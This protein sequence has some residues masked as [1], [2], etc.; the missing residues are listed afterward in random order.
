M[1][2]AGSQPSLIARVPWRTLWRSWWLSLAVYVG[3]ILFMTWPLALHATTHLPQGPTLSTSVPLFNLWTFE[4][5]ADRALHG[6]RDYWHAPIFHPAREA[7]AFSEPQPT[8]LLLAP[9]IWLTGSGE[10]AY[11]VYF[12]LALLLNAVV[13]EAL[14]RDRGVG[15]GL[16][17]AGGVA[18]LLLPVAHW[19]RDVLQLVP[20][21]GVIWVWW[22]ADRVSREATLRRGVELGLAAG[23]TSAMCLHYGLFVAILA[24]CAGG[25]LVRRSRSMQTWMSWGAAIVVA[26]LLAGPLV[27][28]VHQT[29]R[30]NDFQ[31]TPDLLKV[32]SLKLSD[33]G[34]P[35]GSEQMPWGRTKPLPQWPAS[36]GWGKV[37][38]A[39][40]GL[41]TGLARR[42]TWRWTV[43]L[44]ITG[45]LAFAFSLGVNLQWGDWSLWDRLAWIPGLA[46]V[47][48]CYRFSFFV[49]IISV[50]LTIQGLH[51]L[52]LLTH[53]RSRFKRLA[54]RA[55][56]AALALMAMFEVLPWQTELAAT[57]DRSQHRQWVEYVRTHVPPNRA[58][59]HLPFALASHL[60]SFEG[61]TEWMVLGLDHQ[62]PMLNGYSGFFPENEVL[63]RGMFAEEGVTDRT[64]QFL[65]DRNVVLLVMERQIFPV[66]WMQALQLKNLQVTLV[67]SDPTGVDLYE[68]GPRLGVE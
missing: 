16:A 24:T 61:T 11:N 4:W 53:R 29:L 35:W 19:Q 32:L 23:V 18:M 31:R 6:F 65:A 27:W 57:P 44:A 59:V 60:K 47:R 28:K 12:W 66:E 64:L 51:T 38:L 67:H 34:A 20:L 41:A 36:P 68:L 52:Q 55:I 56:V 9:L 54:S 10:L 2:P 50:L 58:I 13:T 39:F 22:A 1:N 42:R 26:G 14:F 30:L 63:F 45:G 21:W 40:V 17:R 33:Y 48:S 43:F 5:N 49:Q 37:I 3:L 62:I 15:R 7:F 25:V 46:Q 8:S